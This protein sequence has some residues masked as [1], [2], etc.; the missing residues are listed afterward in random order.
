MMKRLR[1]AV[2]FLMETKHDSVFVEEKRAIFN[3]ANGYYVDPIYRDG[4]L[5]LW[6]AAG[7]ELSIICSSSRFIHVSINLGTPFLCTF[8]HAPTDI[9]ERRAFWHTISSLMLRVKVERVTTGLCFGL[10]VARYE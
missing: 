7:V 3:Y 8:V 4:G 9:I 10:M 2:I 6:W 5:S 1:P